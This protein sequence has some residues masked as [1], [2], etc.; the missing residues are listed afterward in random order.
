MIRTDLSSRSAKGW[1]ARLGRNGRTALL[2]AATVLGALGL[3]PMQ[4]QA[5][6]TA[7]FLRE[8]TSGQPPGMITP[9][10]LNNR[11]QVLVSNY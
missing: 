9:V 5:Q 7:Q 1:L 2:S 3:A 6:Y 11:G 4:V 10:A 8:P